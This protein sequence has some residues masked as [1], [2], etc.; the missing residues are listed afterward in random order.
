MGII[1]IDVEV[2]YSSKL[3]Y[4]LRRQIAEQFCKSDLFD[5]FL[6]SVSDGKQCWAGPRNKFNWDSLDGHTLI[7]HNAYWE[8]TCYEEL[9]RRGQAP[10][11]NIPA[12]R[13]TADL[14]AYIC[15][16]R[17][18]DQA[19][20]HLFGVR[21]SKA[22]RAN[23]DGK[24][25]PTD[26]S[27]EQQASM[28]EYARGDSNW[29]HAIWEKYNSQWPDSE[30]R[31]SD[32]TI[33][34]GMRGV[35]IDTALLDEYIVA[36]HEMKLNTERLLPWIADTES[37]EWTD[38]PDKPT[39][40]KAI[41]EQCRRTGIPCPPVKAHEGEEAY[42]EWEST[43]GANH[44]W[45]PALTSWRSINKLY[46]TFLTVKERLRPDGTMPF[47]LKYFGAHTGR[48]S[49]DARINMQNMR[50]KPVLSDERGIM[51][52]DEKIVDAALKE[53]KA[54]GDFPETVRY[55]I[56]FRKLIIPRPGK[57]MIL[58]DLAQIEPRVLAWLVGDTAKLDMVKSGMSLYEA[59]ARLN[60]NYTGEK[61]PKDDPIYALAKA[62]VLALGYQAGYKKFITMAYSY[63]GYDFTKDDPE[64]LE[65]R[66][67]VT[68]ET[69]KV[70][71]WGSTAKKIVE[72]FRK[73][74]PQIV[75]LWNKLDL[76]FKQSI[77]SKFEM[78]LPSGRKLRYDS[79][80]CG[81]RIEVDPKTKQPK[82]KTIFTADIAGRRVQVYGGFLVENLCQAI[83]RDLFADGL[84]RLE[85]AGITV[86][87]SS[88]DEAITE[89]DS[90]VSVC[91]IEQLMSVT[92][93][94]MPGIPVA[95]EGKEVL[96]YEK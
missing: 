32:L 70:T 45:I 14:S 42:L 77:G 60:M 75:G 55:V 93:D 4:T 85:Q 6:I 47:A 86:L 22:A 28:I 57:K 68:G 13:C 94:W 23:A 87:F 88:H 69:E 38:F 91:D 34:Q 72:Q 43:Y 50:K 81:V 8:R 83:S 74:N 35:Q 7:S 52:T 48:W 84:L 37:D 17:A 19:V 71:G 3:K 61:L 63:T 29:C 46:Q 54:T 1:A 92:P 33:R 36:T 9:V 53:H 30:Q 79:V 59:S 51:I 89:V 27:P 76:A 56:D 66:N 95:A 39:S 64:W 16:R 15:N 96:H 20:E 18:L 25:W 40:T 2:F 21:I 62:Q 10:R 24:K 44:S 78:V 58:S 11:L 26:F 12:W 31:L 41:A 73:E 67:P 80:K 90:N 82:R 5:C 65:V 49:G